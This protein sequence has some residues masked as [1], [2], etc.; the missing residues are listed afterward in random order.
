MHCTTKPTVQI[1]KQRTNWKNLKQRSSRKARDHKPWMRTHHSVARLVLFDGQI[2]RSEEEDRD[3]QANISPVCWNRQGGCRRRGHGR[4]CHVEK[5]HW[6]ELLVS[7]QK[8]LTYALVR[9]DRES[10]R[11]IKFSCM[12]SE[13]RKTRKITSFLLKILELGRFDPLIFS[14]L[15]G[16][17]N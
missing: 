5:V 6:R 11:E 2:I 9:D 8:L 17:R 15:I 7:K 12:Q 14:S 3:R 13:S 4:V 1:A 10:P 16:F